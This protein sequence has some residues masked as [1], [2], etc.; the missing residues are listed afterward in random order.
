MKTVKI[1]S[2]VLFTVFAISHTVA[3]E[4]E[5]IIKQKAVQFTDF[6]Y[7]EYPALDIDDKGIIEEVAVDYINGLVKLLKKGYS[8]DSPKFLHQLDYIRGSFMMDVGRS[9]P[10]KMSRTNSGL[11]GTL[12]KIQQ[13]TLKILNELEVEIP[14]PEPKTKK[15][16][17]KGKKEK[18]AKKHKEE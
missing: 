9:M 6:L 1:I 4:E 15:K 16:K 14:K 13:Q 5:R 3:Q 2:I 11:R 18:E 10:N 7:K 17:P 8:R 12:P